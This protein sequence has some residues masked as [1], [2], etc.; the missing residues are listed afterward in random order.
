MTKYISKAIVA[1]LITAP[2]MIAGPVFAQVSGIG[3][4]DPLIAIAKTKALSAGF[5]Q[6]NT[7]YATYFTQIDAKRNEM[8]AVQKTLDTNK[9]NQISDD[10]LAAAQK[11]KNPAIQTMQTKQ[12]EISQLQQPIVLAQY[13]VIESITAQFE[14]AVQT[15]VANKKLSVV[16]SPESAVYAPPSADVTQQ[17]VD[18][19]DVRVPAVGTT[20]PANWRPTSRQTVQLHQQIIQLIQAQTAQQQQQKPATTPAA[21]PQSR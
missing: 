11:A 17:I 18:A 1:A 9:D 3:I 2:M 7:T 14:P 20:P 15:V 21:Q 19:L 6:I 4:A 5:T 13:F 10:E 12:Q 8:I 16:L